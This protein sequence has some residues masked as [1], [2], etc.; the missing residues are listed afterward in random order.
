[1]LAGK[2]YFADSIPDRSGTPSHPPL[3]NRERDVLAGCVAGKRM[4]EIAAELDLSI[5]TV[6]TY[7]RRILNK[8]QLNSVADLV[9]H[10]IDH[11]LL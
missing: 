11:K 1:V 9:R 3:S 6:S 5:K 8:L 2:E 10:A 4:S 7:K